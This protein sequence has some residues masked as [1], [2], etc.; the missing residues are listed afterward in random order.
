VT[1]TC[2]LALLAV[3]ALVMLMGGRV[4]VLLPTILVTWLVTTFALA[5]MLSDPSDLTA[6]YFFFLVVTPSIGITLAAV[7]ATQLAKLRGHLLSVLGMALLGWIAGLVVGL[8]S[9]M[10]IVDGGLPSYFWVYASALAL[11]ATYAG[12]AAAWATSV[13]R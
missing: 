8:L 1:P 2:I 5:Y 3:P 9:D 12:S 6:F 11:P 7:L 10:Y 4:R 13:Q